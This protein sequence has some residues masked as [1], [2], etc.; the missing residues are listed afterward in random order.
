MQSIKKG[1]GLHLVVSAEALSPYPHLCQLWASPAHS[2]T[3][4]STSG[5]LIR[6]SLKKHREA[7]ECRVLDTVPELGQRHRTACGL[8]FTLLPLPQTV[9][10]SWFACLDRVLDTVGLAIRV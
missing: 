8:A 4:A 3:L 10:P 2:P 6:Q 9:S 1:L 5:A 7:V